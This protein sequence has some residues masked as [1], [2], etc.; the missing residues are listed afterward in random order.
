MRQFFQNMS[1]MKLMKVNFF[2]PINP[3]TTESFV[4]K[5]QGST[6]TSTVNEIKSDKMK[7]KGIKTYT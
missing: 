3:L 4:F 6:R 1:S 7:F 2:T 5:N